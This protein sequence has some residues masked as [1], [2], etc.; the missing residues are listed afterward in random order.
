MNVK[1]TLLT[2]KF[3]IILILITITLASFFSHNFAILNVSGSS[4]APTYLDGQFILLKKHKIIN[5]GDLVIFVA[6]EEW[7]TGKLG[8]LKRIIAQDGDEVLI[9]NQDIIVNN[10]N[11]E[12]GK[13]GCE[14]IYDDE[15]IVLNENEYLVAGDNRSNSN[16]G[17]YNYCV[18]T[19]KYKINKENIIMV[20]KSVYVLGGFK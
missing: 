12:H 4:M 5:N 9:N 2:Y 19:N 11:Q 17:I 3:D 18:G 6:P 1:N 8:L 15:E 7:N 16:D 10:V 20:G 13:A 14:T